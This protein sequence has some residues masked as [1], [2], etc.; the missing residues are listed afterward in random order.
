[1]MNAVMTAAL[2]AGA[3][4]QSA[5]PARDAQVVELRQY[6]IVPG[7]RDTFVALFDRLFVES[8]EALG[9]RIVGQYRDLDD[10]DRFVWIR[11]FTEMAARERGLNAF[12]FGPVWQAHRDE[13][14]PM[15][16]D[17]DNVL[18]LR[19]AAGDL[20]FAPAEPRAAPDAGARPGGTLL[21]TII[22]LWKPPG[23]GFTAFFEAEMKPAIEAAGLPLLGGYVP[24]A[25]ENNFP[26]LPVR[27]EP[28][29][30]VWFTRADD[31]DALAAAIV[32]LHRSPRWQE[33]VAPR[34]ARF[35]ERPAQALRLA[36]TPRSALR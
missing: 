9:M 6:R 22:Y 13:A 17:N 33:R 35:S 14:N 30:F 29:L 34:L 32:R 36:P 26:R 15:L 21:A 12:Y 16:D 5:E 24:E 3:A 1:M 28:R 8:Q 11:S 19:A 27:R 2:L 20:A 7:Q 23:E 25:A 18:L 4:A 31:A 10:P